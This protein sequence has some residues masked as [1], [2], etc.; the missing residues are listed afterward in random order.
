ME[1][2]ED[3]FFSMEFNTCEILRQR[4]RRLKGFL[5]SKCKTRR[6]CLDG[7]NGQKEQN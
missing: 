4:R 7:A 5:D 3:N 2:C 6:F 1:V